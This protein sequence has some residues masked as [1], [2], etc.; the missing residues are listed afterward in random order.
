MTKPRI[1]QSE[2]PVAEQ[3]QVGWTIISPGRESEKLLNMMTN[4]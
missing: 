3:M 2:E 4:K 1:G